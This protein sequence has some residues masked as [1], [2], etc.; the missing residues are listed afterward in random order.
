MGIGVFLES[1]Q[2]RS[3]KTTFADSHPDA[4]LKCEISG[5]GGLPNAITIDLANAILLTSFAVT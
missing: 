4:L 3:R 1:L 2:S 5:L